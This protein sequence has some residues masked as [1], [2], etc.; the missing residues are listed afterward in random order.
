MIT[1]KNK[2]DDNWFP[3]DTSPT[4]SSKIMAFTIVIGIIF[5]LCY[6][7]VSFIQDIF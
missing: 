5:F 4:L 7:I 2:I 1:D 3:Y 6:G